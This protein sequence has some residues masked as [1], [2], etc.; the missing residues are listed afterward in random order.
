M[1]HYQ[2]VIVDKT[3]EA[4]AGQQTSGNSQALQQKP[5]AMEVGPEERL[6][7]YRGNLKQKWEEGRSWALQTLDYYQNLDAR[8]RNERTG[9]RG[10]KGEARQTNAMV[11]QA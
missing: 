5:K 1:R 10:K 2:P 4:E 7:P 11:R 6:P 3:E 8:E 9:Y